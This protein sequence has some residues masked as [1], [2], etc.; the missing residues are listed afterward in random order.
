M[1][2]SGR[3]ATWMTS[4]SINVERAAKDRYNTIPSERLV[5]IYAKTNSNCFM[6]R[7]IM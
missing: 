5:T 6:P 1:E 4:T 2:G 7:L 3:G